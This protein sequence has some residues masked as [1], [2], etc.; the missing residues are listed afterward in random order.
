MNK[1]LIQCTKEN[2]EV[3]LDYLKQ[4]AERNIFMIA[5]IMN[6]GFDSDMQSVWAD[7]V[8]GKCS[9]VYLWFCNNLL[10]YSKKA[11]L[12]SASLDVILSMKKLDQ[13]MAKRTHLEQICSISMK[14]GR[15]YE[16]KSKELL[17]LRNPVVEDSERDS[18][19]REFSHRVGQVQDT[20]SIYE[21]LQSG[22]LAP[23]YRSREMIES[24]I[25]T[26]DGV[27]LLIEEG[28]QLVAQINSAAKTPYS[29]MLGGLFTQMKHR[30]EGMASYLVAVLCQEMLR[31]NRIPC[32]ITMAPKADN[33]FYKLGFEKVDDF[34]TLEPKN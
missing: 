4:E 13:V 22:E 33:L 19:R 28:D 2:Q 29:V 24:R 16:I 32:I 31:S 34:T 14:I 20:D 30:G 11:M 12:E 26:G 6:Y 15:D 27:H 8:D 21:F 9:A 5:D 18:E 1:S 7:M 3:L 23:L 25:E 10:I 17:A